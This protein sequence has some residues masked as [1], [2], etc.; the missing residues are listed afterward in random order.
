M[1]VM[2]S[3]DNSEHI[4][5]FLRTINKLC[6]AGLQSVIKTLLTTVLLGVNEQYIHPFEALR[7][8][9]SDSRA[10]GVDR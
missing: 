3:V 10:G 6:L 1:P 5:I 7:D 8:I 9:L 2:K 4:I